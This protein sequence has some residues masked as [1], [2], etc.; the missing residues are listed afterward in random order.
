MIIWQEPMLTPSSERG[1]LGLVITLEPPTRPGPERRAAR[2]HARPDVGGRVDVPFV[3]ALSDDPLGDIGTNA[4]KKAN[5]SRILSPCES[6][7]GAG[8]TAD[9][10]AFGKQLRA[11]LV[12][13]RLRHL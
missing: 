8:H 9:R 2:K 13:D 10:S 6:H 1:S 3:A 7:D 5:T 11:G 4:K 12:V